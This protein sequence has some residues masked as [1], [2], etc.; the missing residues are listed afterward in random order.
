MKV[1]LGFLCLNCE[2]VIPIT[3]EEI[4]ACKIDLNLMQSLRWQGKET[5]Y[6]SK[7][8]L[9]ISSLLY[10]FALQ[11]VVYSNIPNKLA[12]FPHVPLSRDQPQ[13]QAIIEPIAL[14][15]ELAI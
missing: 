5:R 10:R 13:S 3:N 7:K 12:S 4:V 11:T 15:P 14:Y 9:H 1:T 2:S 8:H 6:H